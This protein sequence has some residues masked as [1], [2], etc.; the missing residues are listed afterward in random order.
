MKSI[1]LRAAER[2]ADGRTRY[3]CLAIEAEEDWDGP[4]C[5]EF[6]RWFWPG[7]RPVKH[8]WFGPTIDKANQDA[9]ILALCFMD[10]IQRNP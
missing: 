7:N 5:D 6:R 4:A 9:R 3:A 1:Y 10:A 2:I 8:G